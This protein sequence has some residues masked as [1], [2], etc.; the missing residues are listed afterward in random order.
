MKQ[1]ASI[2]LSKDRAL[3]L[4]AM[5]ESF[6]TNFTDY[7]EF[8][9]LFVLY[10]ASND[11]YQFQYDKLAMEFPHVCFCKEEA[12]AR[13][14]RNIIGEHK[15][16]FFQVDDNITTSPCF[17]EDALTALESP[18][19]I[20]FSYRL[21]RNTSY[22]YMLRQNQKIPAFWRNSPSGICYDWRIEECDYGYPLEVSSSIYR[23][24]DIL[25][26]MTDENVTCLVMIEG[27]LNKNKQDFA[28]KRPY[29]A[30]YEY[31]RMFSLPLNNTSG[32]PDNRAGELKHYTEGELA[33]L[34]DGGK[35]I[36]VENYYGVR[37]NSC[38]QEFPVEFE[39][40]I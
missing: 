23:V 8:V 10:V 9:D 7:S 14:I 24:E 11:L 28:P 12:I 16:V 19:V 29:L 34:F 31:S 20:G 40:K 3:Q 33:E 22:C 4:R 36:K 25:P 27:T 13:D 37:T 26:Y 21:G 18:S 38:H 17:I 15:F 32:H 2:I 6:N 30:C 39:D 5:L 1:V 35:R